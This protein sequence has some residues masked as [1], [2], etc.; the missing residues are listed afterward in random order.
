MK[1]SESDHDSVNDECDSDASDS[2]GEDESDDVILAYI[3]YCR[4]EDVDERPVATRS[5]RAITRRA[6]TDFSFF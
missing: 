3:H 5:G 6:E 2:E 1:P 4:C